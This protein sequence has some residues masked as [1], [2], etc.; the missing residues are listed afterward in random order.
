MTAP[1]VPPLVAEAMR[2]AAIVWVEPPGHPVT[3]AWLVW[4][5]DAAY[6]VSGGGEQPVPGLADATSCTV[7]VRGDSGGRI[8]TWPAAVTRVEPGGDVW[9]TVVPLLVG[10]RLNLVGPDVAPDRWARE[11]TVTRLVPAGDPEDLPSTSGAAAPRP[12][13]ATTPVHVPRTL[14]RRRRRRT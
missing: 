12:T 14:H 3:A 8:V 6:L 10:K 13:P 9:T 1:A 7:T 4:H 5:D 11:A 2:K